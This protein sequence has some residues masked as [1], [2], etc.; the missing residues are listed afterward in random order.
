M[1]KGGSE[2]AGVWLERQE[3]PGEY[4]DA[5]DCGYCE[6]STHRHPSRKRR[7]LAESPLRGDAHGG[8]G[9]AGRG[10]GPLATAAPRP[11]STLRSPV[12]HDHAATL[13]TSSLG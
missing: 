2:P 6:S 10:N 4:R 5:V 11:G 12:P 3:V 7:G 13:L 1:A 8:F 9:G